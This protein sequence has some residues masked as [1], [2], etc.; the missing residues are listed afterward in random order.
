MRPAART[1]DSQRSETYAAA[2]AAFTGTLAEVWVGYDSLCHIAALVSQ[3][4]WWQANAAHDS[5][6]VYRG[7][8]RA[9][10][11]TARGQVIEIA[12]GAED[13]HTLTHELAHVAIASW[14]GHDATFRGMFVQLAGLV[15]GAEA[16][17]NLQESFRAHRLA[18]DQVPD[19]P[20][21]GLAAYLVSWASCTAEVVVDHHPVVRPTPT[22]DRFAASRSATGAI[23]L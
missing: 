14:H 4:P 5:V 23:A 16:R 12:A 8:P 10:R 22:V 13:L 1:R 9:T 18:V 21:L 19:C 7:S 2:D 20:P 3:S 15:C 11:S 6:T 17:D